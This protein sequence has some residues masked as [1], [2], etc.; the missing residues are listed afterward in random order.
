MRKALDPKSSLE[1]VHNLDCDWKIFH[2]QQ[3]VYGQI[4]MM[5]TNQELYLW[6]Y[7]CILNGTKVSDGLLYEKQP[8]SLKIVGLRKID[9]PTLEEYRYGL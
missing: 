4:N 6:N 5:K 3:T 2:P 9:C 1:E 8:I 7:I